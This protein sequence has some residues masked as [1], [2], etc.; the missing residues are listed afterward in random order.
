MIGVAY[1]VTVIAVDNSPLA[2]AKV[3][4]FKHILALWVKVVQSLANNS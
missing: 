2:R 4:I 1:G 3:R